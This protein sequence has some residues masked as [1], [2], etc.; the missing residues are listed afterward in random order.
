MSIVRAAAILVVLTTCGREQPPPRLV[1]LSIDTLRADHLGCYGA[2]RPT[3]PHIDALAAE[4]VLFEQMQ[5]VS[6][7]TA[8]AHMTMMTGV[9][10][11]V[12]LIRNE[13][14][15]GLS[16]GIPTLAEALRARGFATAAFAGGGYVNE[17]LGF[18]RGFDVFE[19]RLEPLPRKLERVDEWLSSL[20]P[21]QPVFLFV[22]TYDVHAP[23][24]PTAEHDIFSDPAYA[25]VLRARTDILRRRVDEGRV[26]LLGQLTEL[27]WHEHKAF[28]EADIRH[29]VDLYDGAIHQVDAAV[30]RLLALVD[31]RLD[32][33]ATTFVLTSDHGEAFK[34]H[35]SF[36]HRQIHQQELS[37]PLIVRPPGGLPGGLRVATPASLVDLT[38][39]LLDLLGE[40]VP[41]HMQGRSL[42]PFDAP[43]AARPRLATGGERLILDGVLHEGRKLITRR[44]IP[45]ELYDL[46]DDPRE[47]RNLLEQ[48]ADLDWPH[49]LESVLQAMHAE[50]DALRAALGSPGQ[51]EPLSDEQREQLEALGYLG[52]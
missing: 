17:A 10:P 26:A 51:A 45:H 43:R 7:S 12:H 32:L 16:D 49:K 29:L 47:E 40:D 39:T 35:G 1:L 28:D 20:D 52:R 38:P 11:A 36:E 37:I 34:E 41:D 13:A 22:H 21:R 25:G 46:A 9:L 19:T 4:S 44:R 48:R 2:S 3:S 18:A 5:S 31:E 30:A 27:F 24:L 33:D 23:Y 8:P 50:A 14:D 15:H 42:L 6:S